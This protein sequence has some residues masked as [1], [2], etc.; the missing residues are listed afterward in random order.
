MK[1]MQALTLSSTFFC[2]FLNAGVT[3]AQSLAQK[4][5]ECSYDI[6]IPHLVCLNPDGGSDDV[7]LYVT[8][9]QTCKDG[10]ITA[11]DIRTLGFVA[12]P[13]VDGNSS[14]RTMSDDDVQVQFSEFRTHIDDRSDDLTMVLPKSATLLDKDGLHYELTI[15]S[16]IEPDQK[17]TLSS[18]WHY[19]GSFKKISSSG[20]ILANG[21]LFCGVE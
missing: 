2:F 8:E 12:S 6:A 15:T 20:K 1:L 17:G 19:A 3:K 7:R 4:G 16:Q 11:L 5:H 14:I 13:T 9:F 18:T 10:N 21:R